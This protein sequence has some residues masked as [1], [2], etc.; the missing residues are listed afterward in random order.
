ML[1]PAYDLLSTRLI[2]E[3]SIDPEE[4][5]LSLNG[6]KSKINRTDFLRF[7]ANIGILERVAASVIA[8]FASK[9]VHAQDLIRSS[10]LSPKFQRKYAD[11][12]VERISRLTLS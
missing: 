8:K 6:K 9:L 4:L 10:F 7:A 12:L 5:A 2:L 3:E 11:I 1:T